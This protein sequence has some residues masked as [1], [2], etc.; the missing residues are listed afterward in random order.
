MRN[1]EEEIVLGRA[2]TLRNDF[3]FITEEGDEENNG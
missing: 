2:E 1:D 3:D